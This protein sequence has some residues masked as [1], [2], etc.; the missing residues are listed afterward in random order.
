MK[1]NSSYHLLPHCSKAVP[2]FEND[3]RFK[4]LEDDR[5]REDMFEDYL[6]DLD[7]KEKEAKK[8][9]RKKNMDAFRKFLETCDYIKVRRLRHV[10]NYQE[11][12]TGLHGSED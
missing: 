2:M 10:F 9:E 11:S 7:K 4:A 5:E 8:K 12:K 1:P 6:L 3:P